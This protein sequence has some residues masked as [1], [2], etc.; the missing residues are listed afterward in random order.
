MLVIDKIPPEQFTLLATIIGVLLSS[1]LDPNEQN[2]VG[3]F[4]VSVG[5]T[6]LTSAAQAQLQQSQ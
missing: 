2:S 5:Q 6:L 3:N 1:E 4:L